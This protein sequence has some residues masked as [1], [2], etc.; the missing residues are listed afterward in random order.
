MPFSQNCHIGHFHF[1]PHYL[2][3]GVVIL[4]QWNSNIFK[5]NFPMECQLTI[6]LC[7]RQPVLKRKG[8]W[9]VQF[10]NAEKYSY[11]VP[12]LI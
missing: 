3:K 10:K 4:F 1:I 8:F 9:L 11:D 7:K 6:S 5:M 12:V 2:A